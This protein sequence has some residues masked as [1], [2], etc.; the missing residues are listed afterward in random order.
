MPKTILLIDGV[1][2]PVGG[3]GSITSETL[4]VLDQVDVFALGGGIQE[5][6]VGIPIVTPRELINLISVQ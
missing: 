4:G 3:R 6:K 1:P 5:T 2:D